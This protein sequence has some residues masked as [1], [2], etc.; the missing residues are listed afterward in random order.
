MELN[1]NPVSADALAP[2]SQGISSRRI[3]KIIKSHFNNYEKIIKVICPKL[4]CQHF[5]VKNA[6]NNNFNTIVKAYKKTLRKLYSE[7]KPIF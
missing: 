7:I 3:N 2:Q 4:F 1:I 6:T 5:V